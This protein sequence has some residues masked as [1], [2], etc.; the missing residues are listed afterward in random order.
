MRCLAFC[1]ALALATGVAV[2][3]AEATDFT[4][5]LALLKV[6]VL[7]ARDPEF[8]NG[9]VCV[10]IAED[11]DGKIKVDPAR[12]SA[13][14]DSTVDFLTRATGEVSGLDAGDVVNASS[15]S[16]LAVTGEGLTVNL[17]GTEIR[18]TVTN[19]ARAGGPSIRI[20]YPGGGYFDVPPGTMNAGFG[21]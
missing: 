14:S 3:V 8:C 12:G 10:R 9:D 19:T 18:G 1:L 13:S 20:N 6:R 15:S 2:P 16:R 4:E 17:N 11:S 21:T 5:V 7:K